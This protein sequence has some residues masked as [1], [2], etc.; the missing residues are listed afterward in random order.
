MSIQ[1]PKRSYILPAVSLALMLALSA[2]GGTNVDNAAGNNAAGSP[3]NSP[4][5]GSGE[6]VKL[7]MFI[8]AGSNQ[9]VVPK[10][11]VAEY[12]KTIRMLR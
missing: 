8:W 7:T 5:A 2:C 4:A 10:E 11:V 9:D 3:D 6:K 12:V 1:K